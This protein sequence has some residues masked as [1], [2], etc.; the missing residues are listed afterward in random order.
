[1]SSNAASNTGGRTVF[2]DEILE[3]DLSEER[4][5]ER[6]ARPPSHLKPAR[7]HGEGE[8]AVGGG[9]RSDLLSRM[10]PEPAEVLKPDAAGRVTSFSTTRL[11]FLFNLFAPFAAVLTWIKTIDAAVNAAPSGRTGALQAW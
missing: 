8:T 2:E 1:M 3:S 6:L 4:R 11:P 10:S 5:K 9:T 7:G